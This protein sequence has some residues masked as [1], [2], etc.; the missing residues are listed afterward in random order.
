MADRVLHNGMSRFFN[1]TGPCVPGEHY[2][3]PA[4]VRCKGVFDLFKRRQYVV[5]HAARQAGKITLLAALAK[6]LNAGADYQALYCS[7]ESVQ[8]MNEPEKG[9]PALVATLRSAVAVYRLPD[10]FAEAAERLIPRRIDLLV[11]FETG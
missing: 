2:M 6:K 7:L 11:H 9:I 5:I 4:S 1:T 10:T 8:G 3:L